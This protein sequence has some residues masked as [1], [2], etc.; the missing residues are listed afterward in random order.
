MSDG[1]ALA[2]FRVAPHRGAFARFSPDGRYLAGNFGDGKVMVWDLDRNALTART[3]YSTA[4]AGLP[5]FAFTPD[6]RML[7]VAASDG[8]MRCFDLASGERVM[9]FE[10]RTKPGW[11]EFDPSG[12]RIALVDQ[13]V[14]LWNRLSGQVERVFTHRATAQTVAWHPDGR[15]LAV[16]YDNGDLLLWDPQTG[17]PQ[18]LPGHTQFVYHLAFDPLGEFLASLSFDG[19]TR[20]W[21]ATTGRPTFLTFQ[22]RVRQFS[23]DGKQAILQLERGGLGVCELLRSRSF[24][25]LASR[26]PGHRFGGEV[27]VSSDGRWLVAGDRGR[28]HLWNLVTGSEEA[29]IPCHPFATPRFHPDGNSVITVSADEV[30]RWPL[31]RSND[32]NQ[33]RVGAPQTLVSSK[34]SEFQRI[35]ISADGTL[36]AVAGHYKSLV[37]DLKDPTNTVLF[38]KGLRQSIVSLSPDNRWAAAAAHLGN[39]VTV[40]DARSGA[41]VRHLITNESA[42]VVFNPD[43]RTLVTLTVREYAFWD[44]AT[45]QARRRVPLD[46]SG[47]VPGAI[48]FSGNGRWLALAPDR[49]RIVLLD[50][51]T[52]RELATL[53]SPSLDN[54]EQMAFSSDG[55]YLAAATLNRAIQLWDL[56]SLRKE[57]TEL[58]LDW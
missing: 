38:A 3:N 53:T 29:V 24:R 15:R 58:G 30:L 17:E 51:G 31:E 28:W 6:S 25:T 54:F 21:D 7:A 46:L 20:F 40:W 2:D 16:G 34:G 14:Q 47:D 32:G 48:A 19:S 56:L 5:A 26:D 13:S 42:R 37:V 9:R 33:V 10:T 45:W 22:T 12:E 55:R 36:L 11:I 49:R 44:T 57:L 27:D 23:H 35:S 50:P 39:G 52:G 43:G 41:L 4:L 1:H 8:V 18:S